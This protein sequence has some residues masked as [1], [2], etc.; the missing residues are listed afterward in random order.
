MKKLG[1]ILL[2]F[3]HI[4]FANAFNELNESELLPANDGYYGCYIYDNHKIIG[5]MNKNGLFIDNQF[6]KLTSKQ[7]LF[8]LGEN[9]GKTAIYT[10][11]NNKITFSRAKKSAF[12]DGVIHYP[13]KMTYQKINSKPK[14]YQFLVECGA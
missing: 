3:S 4:A 14:T 2:L 12:N 7:D 13:I 8:E 5:S 10:Y 11:Q 6:F 9:K 1:L